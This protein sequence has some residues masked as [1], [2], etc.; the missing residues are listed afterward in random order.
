MIISTV[1]TYS[2]PPIVPKKEQLLLSNILT[3]CVE[4]VKAKPGFAA[5]IDLP[6]STPYLR[7]LAL[8]NLN[9]LPRIRS[10]RISLWGAFAIER[11]GHLPYNGFIPD[12]G[13]ESGTQQVSIN[14]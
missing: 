3:R 4:A 11:P 2:F 10:P 1:I 9:H 14:G 8:S 12:S 6:I 7:K 5:C 13:L